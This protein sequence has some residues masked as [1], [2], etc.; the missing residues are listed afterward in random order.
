MIT[1]T[2]CIHRKP[3]DDLGPYCDHPEALKQSP[4]GLDLDVAVARFC[5]M[6]RVCHESLSVVKPT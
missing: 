1:C 3:D 6:E 5:T 4:V 2:N